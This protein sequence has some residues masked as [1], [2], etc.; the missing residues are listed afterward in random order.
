M[1]GA[2]IRPDPVGETPINKK[3]RLAMSQ[4]NFFSRFSRRRSR[5]YYL[6]TSH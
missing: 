6:T 3:P 2:I 4:G 5:D 1:E